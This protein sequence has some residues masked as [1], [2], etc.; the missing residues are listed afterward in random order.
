M[1]VV[2]LAGTI[3]QGKRG[4]NVETGA[5][6]KPVGGLAYSWGGQW[7]LVV[8]DHFPI[9]FKLLFSVNTFHWFDHIHTVKQIH[10]N[11]AIFKNHG[12]SYELIMQR[13]NSL[14]LDD[15]QNQE[16]NIVG[17]HEN[18]CSLCSLMMDDGIMRCC[19]PPPFQG[20][21]RWIALP[22]R[23]WRTSPRRP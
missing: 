18:S 23:S 10:L 11:I 20:R 22:P 5:I 16:S 15:R 17:I 1:N 7:F 8:T 4:C 9:F 6:Q 19:A 12:I 3:L 13:Q 2:A 14:Q 21:Q